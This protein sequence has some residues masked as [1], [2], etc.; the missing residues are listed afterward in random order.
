MSEELD[1]EKTEKSESKSE[2]DNSRV[3]KEFLSKAKDSRDII[4]KK[5]RTFENSIENITDTINNGKPNDE[6]KDSDKKDDVEISQ[7]LIEAKESLDTFKKKIDDKVGYLAALQEEIDNLQ[8][9]YNR[10]TEDL[11]NLEER[12]EIIQGSKESLEKEFQELLKNNEQLVKTYETRQVD[13]IVLTDSVKEKV[14]L[15]DELRK[16]I[17]KQNQA[18]QDNEYL[19]DRQ[20]EDAIALEKKIKSQTAENETL[21]VSIAKNRFELDHSNNEIEAKDEEKK[22]LN[23]QIEKKEQIL[24]KYKIQLSEKQQDLITLESRIQEMNSTYISIQEQI[25]NKDNLLEVNEKHLQDIKQNIESTNSEYYE[26]EER[27][28]SL[29]EKLEYMQNEHDKLIKAKEIIDES[30]ND[31]RALLQKLK[32]ELDNQENE[33]RDKESR[34]HR[35]ELLSTIYRVSKF[36]GGI[37]IGIGMLFVIFSFGYL[38]NVIDFGEMDS[39]IFGIILLIGAIFTLASGIFHLEK[40]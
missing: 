35:L 17:A 39:A 1:E 14:S 12:M 37:L 21:K 34:I 16:K 30:T 3:D 7:E 11:Q 33:I 32:I 27:L 8:Q 26:R 9:R 13:L 29:S 22:N 40:S 25:A 6:R 23:E 18:I 19:L 36:F 31:S 38:I 5:L 15:Q 24:A 4:D 2:K 20:R 10:N 28:N